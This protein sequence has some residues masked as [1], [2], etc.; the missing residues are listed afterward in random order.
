MIAPSGCLEEAE[1]QAREL[2]S[3]TKANLEN[4]APSCNAR[5]QIVEFV[6]LLITG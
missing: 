3:E 6:D 5:D 2:L 4:F 1:Q